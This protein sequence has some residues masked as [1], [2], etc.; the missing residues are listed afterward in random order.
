MNRLK[1]ILGKKT[2]SSMRR[3]QGDI[4]YKIAEPLSDEEIE[5]AV[6]FLR[7]RNAFCDDENM[8]LKCMDLWV[9]LWYSKEISIVIQLATHLLKNAESIK[10]GQE[11]YYLGYVL[12]Y[13][14]HKVKDQTIV[15]AFL[16]RFCNANNSTLRMVAA[17]YIVDIDVRRGLREMLRILPIVGYDHATSDSIA[18]WLGEK[19]DES[20][21]TEIVGMIE[22]CKKSG[23]TDGAKWY[24]W[25][26]QQF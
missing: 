12:S 13:I 24:E 7:N 10:E 1:R 17:E 16:K 8:N 25:A 6:D 9:A 23:D 22:Q 5:S 21:K 4:C 14:L 3:L 19:G 20:L 11:A 2:N 18:M 15:D 26:T